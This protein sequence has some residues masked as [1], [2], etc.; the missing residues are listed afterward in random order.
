[1]DYNDNTNSGTPVMQDNFVI[2]PTMISY[3]DETRKWALFLSIIG[4]IGIIL[5]V[6]MGLFFSVIMSSMGSL[7]ADQAGFPFPMGGALFGFIYIVIAAFYFFPVYYNYKFAVNT[8][9][10]ILKQ[11]SNEIA[12]AF[13]NLKS[14]YKFMGILTIVVI[15]IYVLAI[16]GMIV[17]GIGAATMF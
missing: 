6:G 3:L 10:A 13:G 2:T 1:M 14:L 8:K 7:F 4:F 11:D 15:S 5:M 16:I 12:A 9:N 17:A